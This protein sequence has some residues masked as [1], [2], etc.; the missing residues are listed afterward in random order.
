MIRIDIIYSILSY[1][2]FKHPD[3]YLSCGPVRFGQRSFVL[4]SFSFV[5]SGV[6]AVLT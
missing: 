3:Y 1:E 2:S 6:Y 5:P 4:R